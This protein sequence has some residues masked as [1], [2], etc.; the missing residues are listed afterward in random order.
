[1]RPA[2]ILLNP[3]RPATPNTTLVLQAIRL[4]VSEQLGKPGSGTARL[5]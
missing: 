3:A 2:G 5:P 4:C 1:V